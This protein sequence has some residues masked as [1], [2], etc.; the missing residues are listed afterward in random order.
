MA[1]RGAANLKPFVKGEARARE[2]GRKAGLVSAQVRAAARAA[3]MEVDAWKRE[4]TFTGAAQKLAQKR[5]PGKYG[6][7]GMTLAAAC[8]LK[9]FQRAQR[10]SVKAFRLIC[11][12]L[13]ETNGA[14]VALQIP[15]LVD[16]VLRD[17]G[18]KPGADRPG[19]DAAGPV[20]D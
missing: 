10:G 15:I 13:G 5:A 11:E 20:A 1:N 7:Q 9:L 2:C 14:N 17:A 16:D 3:G 19:E 18:P 4:R 8:T 6:K 12:L